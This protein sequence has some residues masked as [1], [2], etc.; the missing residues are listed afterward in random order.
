MAEVK[1]HVE[2]GLNKTELLQ[3]L[4]TAVKKIVQTRLYT[5]SLPVLQTTLRTRLLAT[6]TTT[7]RKALT[8][9]YNDETDTLTG[10]IN[11]LIAQNNN[12]LEV[13]KTTSDVDIATEVSRRDGRISAAG[14]TR[15]AELNRLQSDV[16]F[17]NDELVAA[18]AAKDTQEIIKVAAIADRVLK[19]SIFYQ[20]LKEVND[21]N[22]AAPAKRVTCVANAE[23][24]YAAE[25]AAY[26]AS[27][28]SQNDMP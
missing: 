11:I 3:P 21:R 13:V 10:M 1:T 7:V 27:L 5:T 18:Q 20:T 26:A 9:E 14:A 19:E 23:A 28:S 25:T 6:T 2:A 8:Q 16:N 4:S 12:Q 22:A 24:A 17:A 15:Q